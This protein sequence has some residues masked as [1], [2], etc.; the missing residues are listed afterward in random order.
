MEWGQVAYTLD[1]IYPHKR[2]F[3]AIKLKEY[4]GQ[5]MSQIMKLGSLETFP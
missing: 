5:G 3:L 1:L 2:K 4:G